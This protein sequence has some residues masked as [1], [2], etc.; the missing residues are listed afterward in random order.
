MFLSPLTRPDIT[1]AVNHAAKFCEKPH[2]IHWTAIKRI[3]RYLQGISDFG[4]VYQRQMSTQQLTGFCDADYGG[5]LDTHR[6]R[7][8]YIFK[9]GSRLIAWNSQG[10][11]CTAQSTTEA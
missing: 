4:L 5:D 11:K 2:N 10:Q 6:S 3:M 7:S 9:F 8:G 1:Y